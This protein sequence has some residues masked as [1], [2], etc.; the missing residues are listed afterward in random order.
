[1]NLREGENREFLN[2]SGQHGFMKERV[3]DSLGAN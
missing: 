2:I 3:L 1:M